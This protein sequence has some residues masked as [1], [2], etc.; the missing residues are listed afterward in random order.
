MVK[1]TTN[2]FVLKTI[3]YKSKVPHLDICEGGSKQVLLEKQATTEDSGNFIRQSG[4]LTTT[5]FRYE[6]VNT[7]EEAIFRMNITHATAIKRDITHIWTS[8]YQ[9]K[10]QRP[11]GFYI[12]V[13]SC[14]FNDSYAV[15]I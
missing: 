11:D 15:L 4:N 5:I 6:H 10:C 9:N 7:C 3:I 12:G 1:D 8:H 13:Q 14:Y 2:H